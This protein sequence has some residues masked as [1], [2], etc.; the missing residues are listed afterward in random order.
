M[1]KENSI[2]L[3]V[4]SMKVNG[5]TIKPMGRELTLMLTAPNILESGA[6]TNSMDRVLKHGLMVQYTMAATRKE[7]SMVVEN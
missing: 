5:E 2:M 6:M 1:V 7:R 4:T 3:M